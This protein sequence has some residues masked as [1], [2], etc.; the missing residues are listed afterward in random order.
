M[1]IIK[2]SRYENYSK[3]MRWRVSGWFNELTVEWNDVDELP[4]NSAQV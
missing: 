2:Y 4:G 3:A 1:K